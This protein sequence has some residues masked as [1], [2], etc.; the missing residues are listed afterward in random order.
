M[1]SIQI[2]L[3][4]FYRSCNQL[5]IFPTMENAFASRRH[6]ELDY[7]LEIDVD[8]FVGPEYSDYWSE[9]LNCRVLFSEKDV[10]FLVLGIQETVLETFIK[11][12]F[13]NTVGWIMYEDCIDLEEVK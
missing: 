1:S 7:Q 9:Q 3:N 11:I 10:P 4:H 13:Q 8:A 6:I 12:L 2:K 5:F